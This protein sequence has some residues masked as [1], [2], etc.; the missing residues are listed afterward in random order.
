MAVPDLHHFYEDELANNP[1]KIDPD[2]LMGHDKVEA[3]K[4]QQVIK[5]SATGT[6][7]CIRLLDPSADT[8][9]SL[10]LA[11][12]NLGWQEGIYT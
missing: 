8:I 2:I 4:A 11:L 5:S 7:I 10:Y 1:S 12:N 6:Q 3:I 9:R